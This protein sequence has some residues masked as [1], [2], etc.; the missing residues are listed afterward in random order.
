M[1]L[2]L[3]A[4]DYESDAK[5]IERAL[6]RA[7]VLNPILVVTDGD[8]AIAYLKGDGAYSDRT[9]FPLPGVLLLD[10]KMPRVTGFEVLEWWKK[11][12]QLK[13][14]VII[15]LSG[16]R[17]LQ[18]VTRAYQLGARTFLVKPPT[19][20]EVKNLVK[21]FTVFCTAAAVESTKQN[22]ASAESVGR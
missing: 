3:I 16:L 11:E 1:Q 7:G 22:A 14:L 4:E 6:K 13:E 19:E 21:A 15:V 20:D 10:L 2:I 9:K 17:E 8:E 18:E 12:P 5:L